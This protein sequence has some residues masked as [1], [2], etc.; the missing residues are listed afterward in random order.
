MAAPPEAAE[1]GPGGQDPAETGTGHPPLLRGPQCPRCPRLPSGP[2]RD[3]APA[4]PPAS[5]AAEPP[6]ASGPARGEALAGRCPR[7]GAPAA[8]GRPCGDN[9][10]KAAG[11]GGGR[12]AGTRTEEDGGQC[13]KGGRACDGCPPRPASKGAVAPAAKPGWAEAVRAGVCTEALVPQAEGGV[14]RPSRAR[15][16]WT[17]WQGGA[18]AGTV[19]AAAGSQQVPG[20]SPGRSPGTS[21]S[22]RLLLTSAPAPDPRREKGTGRKPQLSAPHPARR[23]LRKIKRRRPVA[24]APVK[25]GSGSVSRLVS[26]TLESDPGLSRHR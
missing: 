13:R 10:R 6:G 15:G 7:P 18:A 19:G 26:Q 11:S 21:L 8:P 23:S 22:L 4:Q 2:P 16:G 5:A 14:G 20:Q 12:A 1:G 9:V 24:E 25:S 17:G 3:A